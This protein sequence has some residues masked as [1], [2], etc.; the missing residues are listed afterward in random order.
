MSQ[1]A[2]LFNF[3]ID[4]TDIDNNNYGLITYK[5]VLHPSETLERMV[6]RSI[7][8]AAYN[9]RG[10]EFTKGVCVADEP[11]LWTKTT[12]GKIDLWIEIGLPGNERLHKICRDSNEV[13]LFLYGKAYNRYKCQKSIGNIHDN[14]LKIYCLDDSVIDSISSYVLKN[15]HWAII[16]EDNEITVINDDESYLLKMEVL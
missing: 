5:S 4:I 9:F 1:G 15:N 8:F 6:V 7:L 16:I 12:E 10:V 13:F 11:D 3:R 14:N 2:Q